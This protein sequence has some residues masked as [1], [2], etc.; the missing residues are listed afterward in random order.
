MVYPVI[1]SVI[2]PGEIIPGGWSGDCLNLDGDLVV[3]FGLPTDHCTA[4]TED[5][6][7]WTFSWTKA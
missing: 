3:I 2:D 4:E 5:K 6:E 1:C 7:K